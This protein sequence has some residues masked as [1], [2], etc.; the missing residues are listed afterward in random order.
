MF[1]HPFKVFLVLLR[2]LEQLTDVFKG[3]SNGIKT[4][5]R[6]SFNQMKNFK[7][8]NKIN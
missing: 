5:S 3:V 8:K 1:S 2:T 4:E 6:R 7:N